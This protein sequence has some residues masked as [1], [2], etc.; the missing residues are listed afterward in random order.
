MK[1]ALCTKHILVNT[2]RVCFFFRL[3]R[4]LVLEKCY[5]ESGKFQLRIDTFLP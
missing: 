2:V 4:L 5:I 1:I 3:D